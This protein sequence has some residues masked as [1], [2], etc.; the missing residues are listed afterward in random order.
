MV[1][2]VYYSSRQ[3]IIQCKAS[4]SRTAPWK[5]IKSGT[6]QMS[7]TDGAVGATLSAH[8]GRVRN[9]KEH[10]APSNEP[11]GTQHCICSLSLLCI[12]ILIHLASALPLPPQQALKQH[13]FMSQGE[14]ITAHPGDVF[15]GI[16]SCQPAVLLHFK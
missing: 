14:P 3:A 16:S 10:S 6:T 2:N 1:S 8:R 13:S 7:S 15:L 12:S 5:P 4:W 9:S 11:K